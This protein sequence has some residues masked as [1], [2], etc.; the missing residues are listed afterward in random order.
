MFEVY[1]Y[2]SATMPYTPEGHTG[3]LSGPKTLITC[4]S[5]EN[6]FYNGNGIVRFNCK[7]VT[8]LTNYLPYHDEANIDQRLQ[9]TVRMIKIILMMMTDT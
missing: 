5:T 6:S 3:L 7:Q 4:K 8:A 1:K 9:L 2:D